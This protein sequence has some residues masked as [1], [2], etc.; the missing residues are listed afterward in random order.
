L[1]SGLREG[2]APHPPVFIRATAAP[3]VLGHHRFKASGPPGRENSTVIK[4]GAPV[5][6]ILD[7]LFAEMSRACATTPSRVERYSLQGA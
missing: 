4:A 6:A 1:Q 3:R 7:R 5:E 2:E